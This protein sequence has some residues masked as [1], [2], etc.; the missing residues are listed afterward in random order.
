MNA[1][2]R[3][4]L[5]AAKGRQIEKL[6]R[7]RRMLRVQVQDLSDKIVKLEIEYDNI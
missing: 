4:A 7:E 1:A 3:E 6:L 5:R 2:D